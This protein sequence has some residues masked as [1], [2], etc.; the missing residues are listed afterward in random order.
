[1]FLTP[2][3]ASRFGLL[4]ASIGCDGWQSESCPR[5]G[6]L[7]LLLLSEQRE[8]VRE[9]LLVAYTELVVRTFVGHERMCPFLHCLA[10][11]SSWTGE[12]EAT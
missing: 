12:F 2:Q 9:L 11:E 10:L 3:L 6:S 5:D 7:S 1:M 4:H 8:G